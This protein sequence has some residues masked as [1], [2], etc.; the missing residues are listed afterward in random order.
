MF[1]W[2]LTVPFPGN[3]PENGIRPQGGSVPKA[4][5]YKTN[6]VIYFQGDVGD[7]IFILK[8]GKVLSKSNDL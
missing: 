3:Y 7:K 1:S 6:S 8:A 5:Q 4:T 2:R